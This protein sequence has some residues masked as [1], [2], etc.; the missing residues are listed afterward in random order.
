M[1]ATEMPQGPSP[2]P[3]TKFALETAEIG[4]WDWDIATGKVRWS[5]NL[6]GIFGMPKGSF[7]GTIEAFRG[8]VHPD[9]LERVTAAI[10]HSLRT[11]E[12]YRLQYRAAVTQG[13]PR[14][15]ETIGRVHFGP[16]GRPLRMTGVCSDVTARRRTQEARELLAEAGDL[17]ASSLDYESTIRAMARL[18]V[19][20]LADW[21]SVYLK[22]PAGNVER[23]ALAHADPAKLAWAHELLKRYPPKPG[24]ARGAE[25]VIATGKSEIYPVVPDEVLVKYAQDD[26][27]LRLLRDVGMLSAMVVPMAGGGDTFGALTLVTTAESGRR[28]E[29]N[30]LA[31]AEEIGRRCAM[32]IR[33]ARAHTAETAARARAEAGQARLA[34][35]YAVSR[36]LLE[37]RGIEEAA[38]QALKAIASHLGW[39]AGFFWIWDRPGDMLRCEA[40]WI[41]PDSPLEADGLPAQGTVRRGRGGLLG[42][43]RSAGRAE[44]VKRGA[45]GGDG[46]ANPEIGGKVQTVLVFPVASD[47]GVLG[48]IELV[49][50]GDKPADDDIAE[51]ILTLGNHIGQFVERRRTSELV[52]QISTPVLS[53]GDRLLLVPVVGVLDTQRSA[54]LTERLLRAIRDH[55]ALA[56]VIDLTGVA[57]MDSFIA[58]RLIHTVEAARLL[59]ARVLVSGLS[60]D[61]CQTLVSLGIDL[62]KLETAGDLRGG[63]EMAAKTG[64]SDGRAVPPVLPAGPYVPPLRALGAETGG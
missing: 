51:S 21:C 9:E 50:V 25:V 19:P 23:R 36:V 22:D 46:D 54:Q 14:W 1:T 8:T 4:V 15:H 29:P 13:G 28:Y 32:A 39:D 11:G 31:L 34:A 27:H 7:G 12:E 48:A 52:S 17:L 63:I 18:L 45:A 57:F 38:P 37:S 43:V 10:Q 59:G 53:I 33:V 64:G 3:A 47:N 60:P 40:S 26:E 41:S 42:R 20:R 62:D 16:D 5:D 56:A 30:D 55:R 35:Q 6:E 58:S 61:V 2:D 44:W 49:S 24:A